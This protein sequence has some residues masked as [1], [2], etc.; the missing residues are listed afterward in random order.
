MSHNQWDDDKIEELLST[1]PKV[2]DT[3]T[4]D[5]ILQRLKDDGVFDEE[6]SETKEPIIT[7]K[8][9]V[10]IGFLLS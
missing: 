5:E 9:S 1:V 8:K 7:I 4:K 3:R 2:K 10:T 6:P